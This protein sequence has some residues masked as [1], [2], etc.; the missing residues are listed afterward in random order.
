MNINFEN[1]RKPAALAYA[2]VQG[3]HVFPAPYGQKKSHKSAEHSGG[4]K[5]GMT[6]EVSEIEADWLRWPEANIGLPTGAVNG[7]FAVEADTPAGHNVDG[8]AN[9]EALAASHGGWPE[10]LMAESP[11]GSLHRYFLHPGGDV[12]I[13]NS[14][15]ELAPGVD[16]RGEGGMMIAP[17]SVRSDGCYRWLNE[18]TAIEPAPDWLL[19]KVKSRPRQPRSNGAGPVTEIDIAMLAAAMAVIPNDASTSFDVWIT[20]MMALWRGCGGSDPGGELFDTWSQLSP[21]YDAAETV[22]RWEGLER[23]P[24]TV[25]TGRS[26]LWWADRAAPGWRRE[27]RRTQLQQNQE[28]GE[29]V[30]PASL[31]SEIMTLDEMIKRLVWIADGAVIDRKTAAQGY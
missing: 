21:K 12:R 13:V 30:D 24:P 17:P 10:T 5:W 7:I 15:S 2:T 25:I 4:V 19:E 3:W 27:Y 6:K 1:S 22:A 16:V 18:G 8:L 9:M 26:V 31:V 14:A 29:G 11:S 20:V 28:I 23:C